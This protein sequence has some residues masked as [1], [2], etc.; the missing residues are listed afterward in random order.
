[1]SLASSMNLYSNSVVD[2]AIRVRSASTGSDPLIFT[3]IYQEE[4]N[5]VTWQR[6]LPKS[7]KN[8]V[9]QFLASNPTFQIS[10]TVSPDRAFSSLSEV[11]GGSDYSPLAENIAAL[12]DMFCCLFELS[13]A[14]LRLTALDK[15]MCPKFHVDRVPCR[16]VTTYQGRATEWL[17]HHV[18]DRTKLGPGSNGLADS[19]SGLYQQHADIQQLSCGDVALLKGENW[20]HNENAGLVHRSPALTEG[21]NRLLLTLDFAS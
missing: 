5:I 9:S 8:T 14:G 10:M 19:E 4:N 11:L 12:V 16:L 13:Q 6:E 3:D 15:A 21:E 20:H 7:L 18:V 1:M 17:P 2:A